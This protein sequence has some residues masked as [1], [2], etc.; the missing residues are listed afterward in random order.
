MTAIKASETGRAC[1]LPCPRLICTV[2][3][4][5]PL[6]LCL[7]TAALAGQP[8]LRDLSMGVF[9]VDPLI[10]ELPGGGYG[11]S[12]V[13]VM[14]EIARMEGW[15]LSYIRC[16]FPECLRMLEDAEIDLM[17]SITLTPDREDR[18]SFTTETFFMD[19][20]QLYAPHG[21]GIESILDLD[22]KR[23]A[24]LNGTAQYPSFVHLAES[25]G[26]KFTPVFVDEYLDIFR[27]AEAGRADALMTNRLFGDR[28]LHRF[29][30]ERTPVIFT[31][32][33]IRYA[34]PRGMHADVRAA[35]DRSLREMKSIAD[36][37]YYLAIEGMFEDAHPYHHLPHWLNAALLAGV[38]AIIA[39]ICASAWFRRLVRLRTASLVHEI[40]ERTAAEHAL[41]E[42]TETFRTL[43]EFGRAIH[44]K[45]DAT[46]GAFTYVSP[47]I[48]DIL[49][50]A[51][52]R[53]GTVES[54]AADIHPDD[55]ERALSYCHMETSEGRD[56]SFAYRIIASDG[57]AVWLHD[58]VTV[59]TKAGQPV[60]L[61]G[62]MFDITEK[63]AALVDIENIFNLSTDLLCVADMT[64]L[65]RVSPSFTRTLGYTEDELLTMPFIDLIHPDDVE[66][67]AR[68]V[69]EKLEQGLEAINF[70][71]RYRQRDGSYRS[72]EWITRPMNGGL[73]YGVA[74]DV[75]ERIKADETLREREYWF[76]ESQRAG[77]VGA[78]RFDIP[79]DAWTSTDVLDEIFG[80]GPE[81]PRT[82]EGW[83]SL[84]HPDEREAMGEYLGALI[85]N[86]T[87]F[88][89]SYRIVRP[90]D[91]AVRWLYGRGELILGP[92]GSPVRMIGT[93]Q[94][95]TDAK[96]A[97]DQII[98]SLHEKEVLLKEVHHR[99]KN[100][101]AI[102]S[103]LLS[104]QS[105]YVDDPRYLEMFRESQG[106][107]RSMALVHEKLYASGDLSSIDAGEYVTT[108][109]ESVART[110]AT[111]TYV[112]VRPDVERIRLEIDTLIPCGL[113]INELLTNAI[114]HAFRGA[115]AGV[116][117]VT[118][119]RAGEG[120]ISLTVADSGTGLPAGFA[121]AQSP[122][123]GLKL[124]QTLARQL[125]STFAIKDNAP[126]TRF[127]FTFPEKIIYAGERG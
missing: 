64:H 82:A 126:G 74:R 58:I 65:L 31:P 120:S 84:V 9:I 121:P 88:E 10:R 57:Q 93:I 110:C 8:A 106:R 111:D 7:P 33:D 60:K 63:R 41:Q 59:I 49:G 28:N 100:N 34:T 53:W 119:K 29:D 122:G 101:M 40:D 6:L 4:A 116:V 71:N 36:S 89:R 46:T 97:E 90:S 79:S 75:T 104:L 95:I 30:V 39:L 125:G 56:H 16:E 69:R 123:L 27:L 17:G 19:W 42:S 96:E 11:G 87:V 81:F 102:V 38:G 91:G 80:I 86:R 21:A 94:D 118:L 68:V 78:Y 23:L 5:L 50:Y 70:V 54:W 67:T 44:W 76:R 107:I 35:I 55:R 32:M 72:L 115:T 14:E 108:L 12:V 92:G 45:V 62:V 25:F 3:L 103:S 20:G 37:P 99:V 77:R 43:V 61:V 52:D 85:A 24:V 127:E 117:M 47:Q 2:A 48:K 1:L 15:H 124:V 83:I 114:K 98:R 112:S 18:F 73:L 13:E 109:A 22:G 113:I 105:G 66:P 26:V 51:P